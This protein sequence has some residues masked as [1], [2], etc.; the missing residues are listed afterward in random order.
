MSMDSKCKLILNRM[1]Q[2]G[3]DVADESST[4]EWSIEEKAYFVANYE[5]QYIDNWK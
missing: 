5:E 4:S 2:A 3:Y 1:G